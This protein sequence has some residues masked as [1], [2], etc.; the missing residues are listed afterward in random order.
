MQQQGLELIEVDAELL[1]SEIETIST[2]A[3]RTLIDNGYI[4]ATMMERV[5][6]LI[7]EYR[8]HNGDTL[9]HADG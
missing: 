5:Q 6:G 9:T 7:H 8:Q 3:G 4:P 1:S 2:Q